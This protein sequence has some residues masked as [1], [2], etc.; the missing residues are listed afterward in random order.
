[1]FI[2]PFHNY[3]LPIANG[4]ENNRQNRND[5]S[6]QG[7]HDIKTIALRRLACL[8]VGGV[9]WL[10]CFL[11]WSF[12]YDTRRR[13]GRAW[14]VASFCFIGFGLGGVILLLGQIIWSGL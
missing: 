1:M 14:L 11:R 12:L 7:I 6:R 5:G 4:N 3:D 2:G 13:S 8:V 9:G 10:C